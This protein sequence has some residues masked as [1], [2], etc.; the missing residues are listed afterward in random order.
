LA[1]T[2]FSKSIKPTVT[3]TT[4]AKK[5]LC[6][7]VEVQGIHFVVTEGTGDVHDLA[8]NFKEVEA[9]KI[10]KKRNVSDENPFILAQ[11]ALIPSGEPCKVIHNKSVLVKFLAVRSPASLKAGFLV[12]SCHPLFRLGFS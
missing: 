1:G 12:F 4:H 6:I 9:K 2:V 7:F 8:H 10:F 3:F 5:E 11:K